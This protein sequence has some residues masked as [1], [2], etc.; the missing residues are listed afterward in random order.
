MVVEVTVR[1]RF[2]GPYEPE[3]WE[4]VVAALETSMEDEYFGLRVDAE[5]LTAEEVS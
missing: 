3:S 1:L 4:D 5:V 2:E